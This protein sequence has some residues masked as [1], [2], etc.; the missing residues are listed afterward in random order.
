MNPRLRTLAFQSNR[1]LPCLLA[2]GEYIAY[3]T[4][5]N[6]RLVK[7]EGLQQK[8]MLVR[9][10][11]LHGVSFPRMDVRAAVLSVFT[12]NNSSKVEGRI[13]FSNRLGQADITK[14]LP[15]PLSGGDYTPL[16]DHMTLDDKHKCILDGIEVTTSGD[17]I[18]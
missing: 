3:S 9:I 18:I 7:Q 6:H 4:I 16:S 8:V 13:S 1:T 14:S 2:M 12:H 17:S 10:C 5:L 11:S 15:P